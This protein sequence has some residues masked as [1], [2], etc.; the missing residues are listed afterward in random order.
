MNHKGKRQKKSKI[1]SELNNS[2]FLI[3]FLTFFA[4]VFLR[5]CFHRE[6]VLISPFSDESNSFSIRKH[7][8]QFVNIL[9][10]K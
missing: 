7:L 1:F 4:D 2:T 6:E 3:F 9:S 10:N 5:R 8:P